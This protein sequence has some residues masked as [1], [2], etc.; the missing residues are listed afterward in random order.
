MVGRDRVSARPAGAAKVRLVL[1][2]VDGV[3]TDGKVLLHPDG[4]ESKQFDI[5]DGTGIIWA[6][7]LGLT[8]GFLSARSS[9]ATSQRAAQLG[10]TL[11]HQGVT[12]KLDTYDQIVGALRLED[13]QVAYMADDLL[14]LPVLTRVGLAAAPADAANEVRRRVHWVSALNGGHGAVR[15]LVELILK[16]QGKWD[17]VVEAYLAEGPSGTGAV[18]QSKGRGA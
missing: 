13:E 9:A 10:V 16:A 5:R 8:V 3:L 12:S 15:E 7:R 11:V 17:G 1:L 4:T 2:D 14:D 6:Q 18:R